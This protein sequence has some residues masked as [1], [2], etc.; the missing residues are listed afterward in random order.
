MTSSI[1]DKNCELVANRWAKALMELACEDENISKE[2]ILDDLNEISETINSS[3]ELSEVINNPSISTEE[4]QK[5]IAE[6]I[7]EGVT[8]LGIPGSMSG[9]EDAIPQA[10][11]VTPTTSQQIILPDA[12]S[13]YNY[14]SQVT[15]SAIPYVESDNNAGGKTVTIA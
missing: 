6:N 4:K 11:T 3:E 7:R 8:V 2:D 13:G 9:T 10:K 12:D 5:L 15:V 14:L 1:K